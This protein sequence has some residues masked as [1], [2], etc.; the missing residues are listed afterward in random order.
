MCRS[1]QFSALSSCRWHQS[2]CGRLRCPP[3]W[4]CMQR[5]QR[6]GGGS[7]V[8]KVPAL[9]VARHMQRQM[10]VTESMPACWVVARSPTPPPP[11]P[12]PLP[13]PPTSHPPPRHSLV[14]A[15][16]GG[17]QRLAAPWLTYSLPAHQLR[18]VSADALQNDEFVWPVVGGAGA[19]GQRLHCCALHPAAGHF[20]CGA[21]PPRAAARHVPLD[22][23]HP[24]RPGGPPAPAPALH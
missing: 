23:R 3:R 19:M 1:L 13:L 24:A 17:A 9:P 16:R 8:H 14:P 7:C 11:P 6:C 4:A 2:G 20:L 15:A 18:I 21:R 22:C 12:P 10:P 5:M